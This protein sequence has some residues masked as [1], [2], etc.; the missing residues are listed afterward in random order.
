MTALNAGVLAGS[1]IAGGGC[2]WLGP[3]VGQANPGRVPV[4]W[5]SG[6]HARFSPVELINAGGQV[7]ARAGDYLTFG[8]GLGLAPKSGHCMF[9]HRNAVIVQSTITVRHHP[10][11]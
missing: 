6:F 9:G 2:L 1:P 8:G 3:P 5:P 11:G 7:I 10:P 4:V